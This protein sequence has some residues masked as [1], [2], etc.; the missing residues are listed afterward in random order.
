MSEPKK[1]FLFLLVILAIAAFFRLW[2]LDSIPPSLWPDEA[3]N[4]NTAVNI[5]DSKTFQVFY[6]ENH[7]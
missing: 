6:P 1:T 7:G 3:I 4:A 5:L 2:Q